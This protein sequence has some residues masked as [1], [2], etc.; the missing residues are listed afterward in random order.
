MARILSHP[1]CE[2]YVNIMVEFINRFIDHSNERVAAHFPATF[3]TDEVCSIV[4]LPGDRVAALLSLYRR[5]LESQAKFVGRF[6]MHGR[7]NQQTYSLFFASN[8]ERGFEKMKEANWSVDKGEGGRFSDFEPGAADQT[9]LTSYF[10]LWDDLLTHFR[11]KRVSMDDIDRFVVRKTDFL[12]K[13]ARAIFRTNESTGV[14]G[15]EVADGQKRRKGDYP[16]GK[17]S[18][19]FPS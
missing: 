11:G 12:P 6:D 13:H 19:V 14:I 2:I 5:Q 1:R 10:A 7:S 3:G 4:R 18:I 15:V 17:V 9:T 16:A 8:S